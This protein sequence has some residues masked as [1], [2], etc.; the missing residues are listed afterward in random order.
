MENYVGIDENKIKMFAEQQLK[1]NW[2]WAT[3]INMVL[4]Y[5]NILNYSQGD[6]V[7]MVYD[8][9]ILGNY[10]NK[11]ANI[12]EIQSTL[13]ECFRLEGME[14]RVD[15]SLHTHSIDEITILNELG[16]KHLIILDEKNQDQNTEGHAVIITGACY[17]N[18]DVKF[19]LL[20]EIII[21]QDP[22]LNPNDSLRNGAKEYKWDYFENIAGNY[23]LIRSK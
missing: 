6:I 20:P 21:I 22:L 3:C 11:G 12:S 15:I 17:S 19:E 16:N 4:K 13:I 18:K 1:S 9:D 14:D 23:C 2:C 10:P 8:K 5:N 7:S